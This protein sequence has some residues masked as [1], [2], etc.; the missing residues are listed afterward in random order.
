M[1]VDD[2]NDEVDQS[3]LRSEQNEAAAA[4]HQQQI[5]QE[6]YYQPDAINYSDPRFL[7]EQQSSYPNHRSGAGLAEYLVPVAPPLGA[8]ADDPIIVDSAIPTHMERHQAHQGPYLLPHQQAPTS[9]HFS[10]SSSTAEEAGFCMSSTTSVAEKAS[11][12]IHE[13]PSTAMVKDDVSYETNPTTSQSSW[14]GEHDHQ[15]QQQGGRLWKAA[16]MMAQNMTASRQRSSSPTLPRPRSGIAE[17]FLERTR[18]RADP[19]ALYASPTTGSGGAGSDT[20]SQRTVARTMVELNKHDADETFLL[21]RYAGRVAKKRVRVVQLLII[22]LVGLLLAWLG[23]FLTGTA[24][25]FAAVDI[26]AGQNGQVF[27]LHF[28]LW[29][30]SPP[31]SAF[32][33]Y[34]YC[35]PYSRHDDDGSRGGGGSSSSSQPYADDA[36]IVPRITNLL[37]LCAGTYS[38]VVLWLYLITGRFRSTS[39]RRAVFMAVTAFALQL[40]TLTF[41]AGRLCQENDCRL[42]PASM[43]VST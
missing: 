20:K 10:P 30:Y 29:K 38:L 34:S 12:N 42:G 11:H 13:P 15:K 28:G 41:F 22:G 37:A 19:N 25:S 16:G 36:P 40:C 17:T 9:E 6:G 3:R 4:L 2:E 21:N 18:S 33:G 8:S 5:Q 35:I 31:D 7:T 14:G 43:L 24:C 27:A 39:W 23:N 32:S 1:I 26:T